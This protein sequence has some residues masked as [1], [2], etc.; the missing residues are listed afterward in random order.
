MGADGEQSGE[1]TRVLRRARD[2]ESG[3]WDELL[4]LVYDQLHGLARAHMG[5]ER[6][7][8]TLQPTALIH[9]AWLRLQAA[10]ED[11]LQ[12]R[13]RFFRVASRAMRNI[14]IDHAR[15][16]GAAKR[17][18]GGSREALDASVEAYDERGVDL[19]AVEDALIELEEVDPK[20]VRIVELRFFAGLEQTQVA[21]VL[22]T[23]LRSVERGWAT[24]RAFLGSRLGEPPA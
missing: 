22:G 20:L 11:S 3:V 21:E 10:G 16:R 23:S 19:L 12:D 6:A 9:E 15:R 4:A 1:V 24:A 8:H 7:G 14:L 2:G 5:A 17:G 18:G 13:E